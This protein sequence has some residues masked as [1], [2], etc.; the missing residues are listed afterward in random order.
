M[1]PVLPGFGLSLSSLAQA[2]KKNQVHYFFS[3][4]RFTDSQDELQIGPMSRVRGVWLLWTLRLAI[5]SCFVQQPQHVRQH[6]SKPFI[7]MAQ[8]TNNTTSSQKRSTIKFAARLEEMHSRRRDLLTQSYCDSM[9]A[10]CVASDE[11]DS[12]LDVLDIMRQNG[13]SQ[14]RSTYR[15]CLQ[16][17]FELSN[18][19]SSQSILLAMRQAQVEP[20]ATDISLVV[21]A[22][23]RNTK[24]KSAMELLMAEDTPRVLPVEA[25]Y[26][27]LSCTPP[28]NWKDAVRL[29]NLMETNPDIHPTPILSTYRAV[30]ENCVS[31]QQAEQAF[32]I[33]M[34]MSRK[35]LK[36]G[37]VLCITPVVISC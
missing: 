10:L 17:C 35:G 7:V 26:A 1:L 37:T 14:Q 28:Q 36:V 20:D 6:T 23:C 22:M 29:L 9:L 34:S 24:W 2:T 4:N 19:D 21:A 25:Y 27:V 11:W 31:A 18:S 30:I 12:V 32:Q 16:A 3:S 13:L 33:L 8:V 5:A 15:A